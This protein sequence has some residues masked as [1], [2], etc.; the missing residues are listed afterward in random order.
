[1]VGLDALTLSSQAPPS[2]IVSLPRSSRQVATYIL[3]GFSG[4]IL[5]CVIFVFPET[6]YRRNPPV[7]RNANGSVDTSPEEK[8]EKEDG[9]VVDTTRFVELSRRQSSYWSSL[10]PWG[11]RTNDETV[12]TLLAR[13]VV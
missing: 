8:S 2:L 13:P 1:M 11:T 5:L 3:A 9:F 6:S 10:K 4:F 7:E 12:L